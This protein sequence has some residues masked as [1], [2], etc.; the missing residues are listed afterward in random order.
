MRDMGMLFSALAVPSA[1][2]GGVSLHSGLHEMAA[3]YLYHIASNH[4][5]VDGNKRVGAVAALAFLELNGVKTRIPEDALV[6]MVLS[7]AK[8][9]TGKEEVAAFFREHARRK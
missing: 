6:E 1:T 9:R 5:F 7:V 8:G 3:A 2:F 4:P